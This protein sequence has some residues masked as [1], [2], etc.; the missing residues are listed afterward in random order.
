MLR[1]CKARRGAPR[2]VDAMLLLTPRAAL[3]DSPFAAIAF[4]GDLRHLHIKAIED[5]DL[6]I[7]ITAQQR[8]NAASS[9]GPQQERAVSVAG[10]GAATG[11]SLQCA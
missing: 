6:C 4:S 3:S 10:P 7:A 9:G 5:I 11:A 1:A 2:R 8:E